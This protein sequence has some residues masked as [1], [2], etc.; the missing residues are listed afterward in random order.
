MAA[1]GSQFELKAYCNRFTFDEIYSLTL[2]AKGWQVKNKTVIGNSDVDGQPHLF[3]ALDNN[4]VCYP[5]HLKYVMRQLH[6][7]HREMDDNQVQSKLDEIGKWVSD[8]ERNT[9]MFD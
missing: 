3:K 9:P 4:E 8:T 2:L 5:S 1:I 7:R 6:D